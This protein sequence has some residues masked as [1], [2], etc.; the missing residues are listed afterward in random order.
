MPQEHAIELLAAWREGAD[1]RQLARTFGLRVGC[2][3]QAIHEIAGSD[4]YAFRTTTRGADP[5]A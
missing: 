1:P 4:D 5:A 3:R 2:V